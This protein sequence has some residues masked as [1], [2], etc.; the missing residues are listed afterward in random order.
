MFI[1]YYNFTDLGRN[2]WNS[3]D[4]LSVV[5]FLPIMGVIGS[6]KKMTNVTIKFWGFSDKAK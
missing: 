2:T 6:Y 1:F 4:G 5:C 3:T